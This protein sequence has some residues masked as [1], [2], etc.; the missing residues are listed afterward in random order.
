MS[1]SLPAARMNNNKTNLL[2]RNPHR[3]NTRIPNL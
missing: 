1:D 3:K 2:T